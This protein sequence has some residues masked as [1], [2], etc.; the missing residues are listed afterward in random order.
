[1][2]QERSFSYADLIRDVLDF[3]SRYEFHLLYERADGPRKKLIDRAFNKFSGG[4]KAMAMYV[5]LFTA[6]SAQYQKGGIMK[7]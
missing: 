3:R 7:S 6:V 1:M 2:L 4:E 5:P